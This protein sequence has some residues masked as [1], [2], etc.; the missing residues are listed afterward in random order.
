[1]YLGYKPILYFTSDDSDDVL[2][3]WRMENYGNDYITIHHE[4]ILLNSWLKYI[5][6]LTNKY[7]TT[8]HKIIYINLNGT[9]NTS[10]PTT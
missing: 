6:L 8:N 10:I 2:D 5:I 1:M 7:K 4:D 9:A 3:V